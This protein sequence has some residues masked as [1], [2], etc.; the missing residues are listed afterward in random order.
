MKTNLSSFN[1][2]ELSW[3]CS[4]RCTH[5]HKYSEHLSCYFKDKL[6]KKDQDSSLQIPIIQTNQENQGGVEMEANM[7]ELLKKRQVPVHQY[8]GDVVR[9]GVVSDTHIGSIYEHQDVLNL[10]YKVFKKEGIERVYHVG[11]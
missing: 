2:D 5:G 3:L 4:H 10:A 11:D 9:F 8:F 7:L 6:T 1:K